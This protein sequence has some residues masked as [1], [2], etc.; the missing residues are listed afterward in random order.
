[1]TIP[2][3]PNE[4]DDCTKSVSKPKSVESFDFMRKYMSRLVESAYI[5]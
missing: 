1:M 3:C 2:S 4:E 5:L